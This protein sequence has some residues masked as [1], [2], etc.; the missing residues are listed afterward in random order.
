MRK[1]TEKIYGKREN[2]GNDISYTGSV[3]TRLNE[4]KEN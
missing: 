3:W 4:V 1:G 2:F